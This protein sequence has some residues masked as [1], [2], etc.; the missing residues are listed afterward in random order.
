[1]KTRQ[2]LKEA[3]IWIIIAI[4]FVYFA[5]LYPGLP[6]QIPIHFDIHGNP[7]NFAAKSSYWWVIASTTLGIYLLMLIIPLIDPKRK[8]QQ[9]GNKYY[10]LKLILVALMSLMSIFSIYVASN[11]HVDIKFMIMILIGL[12]FM[13]LG[14]YM[15]SFKPNYFIGIRTPWTLESEEIWRKTHRMGGWLWTITGLVVIILVLARLNLAVSIILLIIAA[16]IPV[17]YSFVL[18]LEQRKQASPQD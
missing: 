8:I 17:I 11:P 3:I 10:I 1:M 6:T 15:P 16:L 5:L 18:Y 4:P 7:D 2:I 13:I 12:I 14:N 9:M